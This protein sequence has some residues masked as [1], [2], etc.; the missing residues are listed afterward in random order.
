MKTW[1]KIVRIV[2]LL[3]VIAP[4][5]AMVAVQIPSV[6]TALV[7]RAATLLEKGLN[8]KVGV[9]KVLFSFPN[10]LILKDID[11]IVPPSDTVLHV[12]KLLASVRT[13]TLILSDE[14][15]IRRISLENA[16]LSI[17]HVDDSTTNLSLLLG[18]SHETDSA[19]APASLPWES[20]ILDKLT[21][22]HLEASL[23]TP[24]FAVHDFNLTARNIRYSDGP[25]A[26]LILDNITFQED[27]GLTV[28]QCGGN[29]ALDTAGAQIKG[30]RY[31]DSWT[32]LSASTL[33]MGFSDF[34]DFSD[35][36]NKVQLEASIEESF[37]D[38]RTV[39]SILDLGGMQVSG[40][41]DT[42]VSG[43]LA[44]L[45]VRQLH[46]RSS[47]KATD[48]QLRLRMRGMPDIWKT[49]FLNGRIDGHTS[50]ADLADIIA[51]LFPGFDRSAIASL[52]PGENL[53][54][55]ARLDGPLSGLPLRVTLGSGTMGEAEVQATLALMPDDIK[56]E[57]SLESRAFNLGKLLNNSIFGS[58]SANADLAL[59]VAGEHISAD[60][61]P[62]RIQNLD[63][64]GYKYHDIAATASM[65]DELIRAELSSQDPNLLMEGHAALNLGDSNSESRY[66]LDLD[67]HHAR[68]DTLNFDRRDGSSIRFALAADITRTP[69]GAFLGEAD[70]NS[71]QTTLG[72]RLFY[73]GD[74]SIHSLQQDNS[75][76]ISL[77]SSLVNAG[78]QGN[79][80]LTDF[81]DRASHIVLEDNVGRL[82]GSR[83]DPQSDVPKPDDS[84]SFN[85]QVI[86]LQPI[87]GFL[88]PDLFVARGSSIDLSLWNDEVAGK[89]SS[90]LVALGD[91]FLHN[92]DLDFSTQ[93]EKMQLAFKADRLQPGSLL[94]DNIRINALA[95]SSV[96]DLRAGFHNG[97]DADN[98]ADIHARLSFFEPENDTQA[99][100]MRVDLL[101]SSLTFAGRPWD[102]SPATVHYRDKHIRIDHFA[103]SSGDQRLSSEGIVGDQL[104]DTVRLN[105]HDFDLGIAN[106]FLSIPLELEGSLTG[107]GEA[108][109]ILG[110]K[111]GL[112][113]DLRGDSLS[114]AGTRLG[115]ML[116]ASHWDDAAQRF[117]LSLDN[118]LDGRRPLQATAFFQPSDKRA[119]LDLTL[120]SLQ[121]GFVEP[122][123]TGLF[124][125]MSGT[126]SGRIKA[127]GPLDKMSIESEGTRLNN[128]GLKLDF[129]Q[130]NYV[131]DGAF[132][133]GESGVTFDDITLRDRYNHES[134][135][136]GGIPYDHFKDIRLNVRIDL[137]NMLALNT[138]ARDNDSFYG[139]AFADGTVRVSGPLDRIRVSLNVTP[140]LNTSVHIPLSNAGTQSQSLLT[141][142]SKEQPRLGVYDSLLL[143]RNVIREEKKKSSSDLSVN[144]R[145]NA[146]PDAEIQVEIDKNTGDVLKARGNGQINIAIG[147]DSNFDIKGEYRVESGS[148][149]F[150]MLSITSR[151]FSINPGGT[152][153]F[154]GDVMQSDLDMTATYRTKA[155]I[156]PLISDSTAV[157]MRRTV[158]CG[159]SLTG[160]LSNP[161]IR[162]NILI[163]DLDP[164]YQNM[165][166]NA[167]NTEDKRMKQA[168]ALLVSGGFV[169]DEQSGIVNSTTMLYSNATELMSSQ[170]NN[171]FRQL[172][173]P[174]DLGFNYQPT[175][176]GRDLFDV[177]V[178]TQLFNNRVIINGN[179]GN[180]RYMSSTNSDIVGDIDI[181]I[182]L[183]KQGQ[184]RLTLFSHSADQFS[185][186]LDLSQ[187]NGAGIVYQEDF[188]SFKELW[189]KIF[190]I[191]TDERKTLSDPNAPRRLPSR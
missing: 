38:L 145:V 159:I 121:I 41:I 20:I 115:E 72:D 77:N 149:H 164:T 174:L 140:K 60:V 90:E 106:A 47:S 189:R 74:I 37:L 133:V 109:G 138:T 23:D 148:Y 87:L 161:E 28:W 139:K 8:A 11:V 21:L 188:S 168:L 183:N 130:V 170:L 29:F 16:R 79:L 25:A 65:Q 64:M 5:A 49:S 69:Q 81:L 117:N 51:D 100:L 4:T 137:E 78:Y 131:A 73:A 190:H 7:G 33:A 71:L 125:D 134:R 175:G 89:I 186:Y 143:S 108:F 36:F 147:S 12:G 35:F 26:S 112:L 2:L 19:K 184:L 84:G 70:I 96:I 176:T 10:N 158:D 22:K 181:E 99:Y 185:N 24:A 54:L 120:D 46:F 104:S 113:F 68:L 39:T 128:A 97:D 179:I 166:D 123:L 86:D 80:F 6:Q 132:T 95:D 42:R 18:Q 34:S 169:P 15:R 127:R 126:V 32:S 66:T 67:V 40:W 62:L 180:R 135:L 151:D 92:L 3:V 116:L 153:N 98:Q 76:L 31:E 122:I 157:S 119:G 154:V 103:L 171:I 177:A 129:T 30:F 53:S 160:K 63:F 178:S 52:A 27:H 165:V 1:K 14:A 191:K 173:I 88:P 102:L 93:E 85:L 150:G 146:T 55:S 107:S 152:I 111:K 48:L 94:I 9:G 182:K 167:L 118:I 43:P 187:R 83:H 101:P 114:A 50:T 91:N 58:L 105:F 57:G 144:L 56:L 61:N 124:S 13:P 82:T 45:D 17:R 156:S 155:S 162:F 142:V 172:D 59:D 141:F 75:F 136:S 110:E 163:P 44:D